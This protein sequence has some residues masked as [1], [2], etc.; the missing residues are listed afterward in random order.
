M[1]LF[2]FLLSN[3][4]VAVIVDIVDTTESSQVKQKEKQSGIIINRIKH[5]FETCFKVTWHEMKTWSYLQ[6]ITSTKR[7]KCSSH[8]FLQL[9]II[10]Q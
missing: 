5:S 2:L 7:A 8:I 6:L 4:F 9:S 3:P 10:S 1:L